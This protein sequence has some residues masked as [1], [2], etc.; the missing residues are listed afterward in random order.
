MWSLPVL[1]L[2][3]AIL[4]PA[5]NM[6]PH[7]VRCALSGWNPGAASWFAM[8]A[9][10]TCPARTTINWSVVFAFENY[11]KTALRKYFE[12]RICFAVP[13]QVAAGICVPIRRKVLWH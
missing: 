4:Q 10:T 1:P 7:F 12:K 2:L 11:C 5:V 8:F 6:P 3:L 9:D 13:A